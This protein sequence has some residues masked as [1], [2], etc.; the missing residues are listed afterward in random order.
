MILPLL[1]GIAWLVAGRPGRHPQREG[2]WSSH[3]TGF[4]EDE[5]PRRAS[6]ADHDAS[7]DQELVRELARVDAEFDEAVRRSRARSEGTRPPE[8]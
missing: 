7:L 5:R 2:V 4:P 1:G 8:S 6:T 3:R